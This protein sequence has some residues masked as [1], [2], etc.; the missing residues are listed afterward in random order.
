MEN[1]DTSSQSS[2]SQ[3]SDESK[4][5]VEDEFYIADPRDSISIPKKEKDFR[6]ELKVPETD[7][8][9][10]TSDGSEG[11]VEDEF[12][13]EVKT[14]QTELK[15]LPPDKRGKDTSGHTKKGEADEIDRSLPPD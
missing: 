6:S 1:S 7:S 11:E 8:T 13:I 9:S 3:T 15:Q 4:E 10:Q 2:S 5:E 12:W 14:P